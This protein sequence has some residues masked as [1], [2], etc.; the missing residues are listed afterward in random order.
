MQEPV[1]RR[2]AEAPD[3]AAVIALVL[4]GEKQQFEVLVRRYQQALHRHA[5]AMVLDRDAAADMVQDAF[6]RAYV[7]LRQCRDRSRYR[8]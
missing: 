6:I 3:D 8:A 5:L 1:D 2:P 4:G 7:N